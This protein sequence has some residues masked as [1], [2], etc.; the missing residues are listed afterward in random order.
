VTLL[1]SRI[2]LP[3]AVVVLG[4]ITTVAVSWAAVVFGTTMFAP[5]L[6]GRI[7]TKVVSVRFTTRQ[8]AILTETYWSIDP[9]WTALE[10]E[11]GTAGIEN[12]PTW[13]RAPR[14]PQDDPPAHRSQDSY[15]TFEIASGWPMRAMLSEFRCHYA[16]MHGP[17]GRTPFEAV[18]GIPL[19]PMHVS[20]ASSFLPRVL[21]VRLILV[22]FAIDTALLA[23]L[24][25]LLL[26]AFPTTRR[27]L[28]HRR[29][30]CL[31]CGYGP[32]PSPDAQCSECGSFRGNRAI[33]AA[34]PTA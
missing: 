2:T 33:V 7:V 1:R 25:W 13:S 18:S 26:F 6:T 29:G 14:A 3:I 27:F 32:L 10:L 22:G 24:W 21:P 31:K 16:H 30:A 12:L 15:V 5:A 9:I 19:D 17:G 28:R 20:A 23:A 4:A 8:T 11:H 34:T